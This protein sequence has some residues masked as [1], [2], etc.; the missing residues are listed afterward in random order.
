MPARGVLCSTVPP[1]VEVRVDGVAV[2][3]VS[4]SSTS[5][6][7]YTISANVAPGSHQLAL[8]YTN[9]P[10]TSTCDRNV[11]LDKVTLEGTTSGGIPPPPPPLPSDGISLGEY[12]GSF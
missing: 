5:Y 7:S 4:V 12:Q 1:R 11:S 8:A 3:A 2:G 6:A 10:L 9:D